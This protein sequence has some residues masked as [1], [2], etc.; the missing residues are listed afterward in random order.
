MVIS[1]VMEGGAD[2]IVEAVSCGV[3]VLAGRVPGNV[4]MLGA[5]YE[6]YFTPGEDGAL[7]RLMERACRE[8]AFLAG[9]RRQCAARAP[10]FEPA[11]ECAEVNRVMDE[12]LVERGMRAHGRNEARGRSGEREREETH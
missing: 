7:A 2:V 8:P 12:A 6:G 10:L 5:D 9:L 4:G 11:R 3:P 1:S